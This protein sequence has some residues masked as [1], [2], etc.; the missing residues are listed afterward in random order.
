[1]DGCFFFFICISFPST[2]FHF[3]VVHGGWSRWSRWTT[4]SKSCGKGSQQ[5]FRN[6]TN[7]R[8]SYG[9]RDCNYG[10]PNG[11]ETCNTQPCPGEKLHCTNRQHVRYTCIWYISL[12]S[13]QRQPEITKFWIF[14][15]TQTTAFVFLFGIER[16]ALNI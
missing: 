10:S 16:M 15:R 13:S 12:R 2:L 8:P 6:C 14:W 11:R 9:G 5:R 1:M 3:N 4:C 7:P